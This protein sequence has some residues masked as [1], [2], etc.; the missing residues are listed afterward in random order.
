MAGQTIPSPLNPIIKDFDSL[1]INPMIDEL[2]SL[3]KKNRPDQKCSCYVDI[4]VR[5]IIKD[6]AGNKRHSKAMKISTRFF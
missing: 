2:R 4:H 6:E 5:L 3:W 1:S